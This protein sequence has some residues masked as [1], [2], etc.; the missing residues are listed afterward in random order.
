MADEKRRYRARLGDRDFTI[1]GNSSVEHMAAVTK[2]LNDEL[3]QIQKLAPKLSRQ[4]QAL[5][6]A[7]NSISDQLKIQDELEELTAPDNVNLI[8]GE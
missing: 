5:L 3:D 2:K 4:D 7:F 1:V 6:L 8:D